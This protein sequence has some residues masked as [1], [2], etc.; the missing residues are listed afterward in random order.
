[1]ELYVNCQTFTD[2]DEHDG[3]QYGEWRRAYSYAFHNIN[4]KS[5][6]R[7]SVRFDPKV[8]DVLAFVWVEYSTGDSFGVAE[9]EMCDIGIYDAIEKAEV[10]KE[11]IESDYRK[12][13]IREKGGSYYYQG[14]QLYD[15]DGLPISTS[16]WKGYFER[17]TTVHIELL[18][19]VG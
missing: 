13:E 6:E 9:G 18:E 2:V 1:M 15:P 11:M 10:V 4:S 3:Q 14:Y 17:L 7:I 16:A 8:G 19:Y 12:Y 5:G